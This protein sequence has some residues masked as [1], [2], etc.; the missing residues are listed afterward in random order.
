MLA[1]FYFVLLFRAIGQLTR[2]F[3]VRRI[4]SLVLPEKNSGLNGIRTHD[5]C[6]TDATLFNTSWAIKPTGPGWS[7]YLRVR[8]IPV[9]AALWVVL[10]SFSRF[11]DLSLAKI[12]EKGIRHNEN[13]LWEAGVGG[14][15]YL[16]YTWRRV[17]TKLHLAN[18][19]LSKC[20]IT[21]WCTAKSMGKLPT[22]PSLNLTFCLRRK[23]SVN[24]RFGEG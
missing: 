13:V 16:Q 2:L 5:R 15:G 21:R 9:A 18:P 3:E 12:R 8:N 10:I 24:V 11:L 6:H 4:E 7:L 23:L 22:Y 14:G 17:P 1:N 19:K 20:T